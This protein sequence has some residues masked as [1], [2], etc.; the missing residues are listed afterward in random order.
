MNT[1]RIE[2]NKSLLSSHVVVD[3]QITTREMHT[4]HN[5]MVAQLDAYLYERTID[6]QTCMVTLPRAKFF[7]WLLRKPRIALVKV[8]AQ[9]VLTNLPIVPCDRVVFYTAEQALQEDS[10]ERI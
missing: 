5:R 7:E 10:D 2:F 4:V 1:K 3:P 6:E 8:S 9:E